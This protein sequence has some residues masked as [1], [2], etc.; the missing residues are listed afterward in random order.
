M[1]PGPG[2]GTGAPSLLVRKREGHRVHAT[3]SVSAVVVGGGESATTSSTSGPGTPER[4]GAGGASCDR[5]DDT[6]TGVPSDRQPEVR[7][8]ASRTRTGTRPVRPGAPGARTRPRP[9]RSS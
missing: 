6:G 8:H 5:R 1:T 3:V 9:R 4:H 7:R 2:D